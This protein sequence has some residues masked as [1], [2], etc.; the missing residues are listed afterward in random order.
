VNSKNPPTRKSPRKKYRMNPIIKVVMTAMLE[1]QKKNNITRECMTNTQYLYD[2]MKENNLIENCKAQAVIV[3]YESPEKELVICPG[4]LVVV[5]DDDIYESSYEYNQN[6][7]N[8]TYFKS[9]KELTDT[10]SYVKNDKEQYRHFVSEFLKFTAIA[11]RINSG[12]ICVADK[13]NYDKQDDYVH[14]YIMN[15]GKKMM[16][17]RR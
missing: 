7:K 14:R 12:D 3:C 10:I 17:S 6:L 1:Y 8:Q 5:V 15:M 4:H 13:K 11:N 9:I 2:T 16:K